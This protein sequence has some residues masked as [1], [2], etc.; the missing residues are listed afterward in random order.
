MRFIKN[1]LLGLL[2]LNVSA[3]HPDVIPNN[4]NNENINKS[5]TESSIG[6]GNNSETFTYTMVQLD[7]VKKEELITQIPQG[8][9]LTTVNLN[10]EVK[11]NYKHQLAAH[12]DKF[13]LSKIDWSNKFN[14]IKGRYINAD[15]EELTAGASE[16]SIFIG[17]SRKEIKNI[18]PGAHNLSVVVFDKS[19]NPIFTYNYQTDTFTNEDGSLSYTNVERDYIYTEGVYVNDKGDV[20]TLTETNM[21]INGKELMRFESKN[22]RPQE[23]GRFEGEWIDRNNHKKPFTFQDGKMQTSEGIWFLLL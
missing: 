11:E 12:Y 2:L 21:Y 3:A 7:N 13:Q 14:K 1:I 18:T 20:L 6:D 23:N 5:M 9:D 4:Y 10:D 15:S 16:G 17:N 19:D 22:I 8:I